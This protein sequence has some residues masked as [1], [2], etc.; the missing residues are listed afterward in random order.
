[1]FSSAISNLGN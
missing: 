1:M